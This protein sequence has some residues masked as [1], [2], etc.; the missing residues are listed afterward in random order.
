MNN[1]FKTF[2]LLAALGGLFIVGGGAIAGTGGLIIGLVIALV[3]I[4]G[5][6]WKSDTLAIKSARAVAVTP[7]Q[8]PE[9]YQIMEEL[10]AKA[11]MPMPKLYIAPNPQPN[12]FATGRNPD[13]A[14]V[15][16]TQ[17]LLQAMEWDEIRGVL[18]HE[19][20]HVQNR[21]ILIGSVAAT[22]ATAI[23]FVATIARFGSMFGGGGDRRGENPLVYMAMLFVAPMAAAVIQGAVSRSRE[24]EADASAA[25]LLG[26]GEPLARALEKLDAFAGRVPAQ[27][28]SQVQAS[29]YIINPLKADA[30]GRGGLSGFSKM[31]STHPP[32][33][34]R[35]AR[36]RGGDWA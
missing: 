14:A 21:D 16:V 28:V 25:Q 31:F 13:N 10:T 35:I 18:A 23:S 4:G 30:R 19:L 22:I 11:N 17:G 5:S 34:E 8:A 36:L 32:T 15:A 9:F 27:N 29:H 3:M 7:Q 2:V 26:S 6:Y 20:A 1:T 12:A 24:F 33:E